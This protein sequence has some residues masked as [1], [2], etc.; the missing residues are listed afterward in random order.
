MAIFR[1]LILVLALAGLSAP[2]LTA[3][4][5]TAEGVG[6]DTER[7]GEYIQRKAR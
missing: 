6:E 5:N 2:A 7:A 1:R 3:C 4:S